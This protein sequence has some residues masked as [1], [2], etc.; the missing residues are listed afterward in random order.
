MPA[1]KKVTHKKKAAAKP[2]AKKAAVKKTPPKTAKVAPKKTTTKKTKKE[3]VGKVLI[4]A[5][6]QECFW[7]TDGQVL[8]DLTELRDALRSMKEG[9]FT[10]HV[11]KEKNDFADWVEHVLHDADCAVALRK[12]KKPNTARTVIVRHLRT[13]RI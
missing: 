11:T 13:Y 6:D 7:T 2:K 8:R 9:V 10:H 12:S 5:N 3:P 4:C 1:T